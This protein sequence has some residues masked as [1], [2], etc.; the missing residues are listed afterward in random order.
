MTTK[1]TIPY[2]LGA[3]ALFTACLKAGSYDTT[4][5]LKPSVQEQSVSPAVPLEGVVA[6]SFEV[7]TL[8][9]GVASYDDALAGII[10]YKT[11]PSQRLTEPAAWAVPYEPDADEAA[12]EAGA[13]AIPAAEGDETEA[14]DPAES[15]ST[16]HWLQMPVGSRPR[17][18]VAVD[19]GSRLYGYTM[20]QPVLNMQRIY[21]SVVFQPW[22]E[23]NAYKVG[24]WSFYN[25]F[26][27]PPVVLKTFLAPAWQAEAD[28][29]ETAFTSSQIKAYA[30]LA[31][32]TD[33]R[34]ASYDDAVAGKIVRKEGDEERTTPNFQAYY[35]GDSGRFGMEVTGTPLMAVV[36][37]RLNRLY[38][39]TKLEP[40]LTGEPPVWPLLFRPWV[41]LWKY[42]DAG[43]VMVNESLAPANE[44]QLR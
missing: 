23:G 31:D 17:M 4:Y 38:A 9:W 37:D 13:A 21:V 11:D 29:E 1:R 42:D 43:W 8:E 12:A 5:V 18:V 7:D 19:P 24:N 25:D 44:N 26:Y 30:F 27:L 35:E 40:D 20:Q 16:L 2:L 28:A 39:Y 33:W 34:V 14:G 41:G 6:Y 15:V 22:K 10:T 3:L 36:V 32:T